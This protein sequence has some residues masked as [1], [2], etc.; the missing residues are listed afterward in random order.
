VRAAVAPVTDQRTADKVRTPREAYLLFAGLFLSV[1]SNNLVTPLL[2]AIRHDVGMSVAAVGLYV[3]AYGMARLVVDLP[4]GALAVRLGPRRM[5]LVGVGLNTVASAVAVFAGSAGVLLAARICAGVGAGLLA[6]VILTAMSDVA[7]PEI[8]GRVMSLYQVANNLGIALYPLLGG[9]LGVLIGWRA[10][11]VAATVAAIGSGL[12]LRPVMG[13]ISALTE[14]RKAGAAAVGAARGRPM[15]WLALGIVFFGVVANMVNRH[16]FRNTVMPLV[17]SSDLHLDGVEI[18]TGITIM[19]LTGI[20][21][22]IPAA[23]L[24]DRIGRN[25]IIISG[26]VAL[27][28]GDLLFPVLAVNYLTY[29]VAGAVIGLGDCFSSSQTATLA[30]LVEGRQRSMVLAAYRFFVDVGALVGPLG[31]AWLLERYGAH[32]AIDTA[33]LLLLLAAGATAVGAVVTRR[34]RV[35]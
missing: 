11:F 32:T 28:V 3:S 21:V 26:L 15:L 13:R 4:S 34:P 23:A 35:E 6:T 14:E 31:L 9:A 29:L 33:G 27:G 19:S 20:A 8:R 24:G 16:G 10:A 22:T 1:A 17:A 7:P 12:V 5:V 30:G 18:A 2:P 25:R